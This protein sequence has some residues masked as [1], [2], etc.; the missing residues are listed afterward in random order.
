MI[1]NLKISA[2]QLPL[3]WE[4]AVKNRANIEK[5]LNQLD[6][7]FNIVLLPEM[8]NSGFTMNTEKVSETMDGPSI[9]WM[10]AWAEKLNI[11]LGGSLAIKENGKVY[12]R[13]VIV[14]S[15]GVLSQ[16]DKR[17]TFTLAEEDKSYSSG[18]GFGIFKYQGWKICLRIC[19]DLRFPV[20][21]RNT[22]NYDLLL[23]VAN[24]PADRISAW[25]TLLKARA[26]EN[27]SYVVGVNRIG[28]DFKGLNYPGH[29]S[30]YD[31]MGN[32][33]TQK[34]FNKEGI[35]GANLNYLELQGHRKQFR[36]LEDRDN[37]DL[38]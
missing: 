13:F 36:F 38:C 7:K 14:S 1:S 8:F 32:L 15:D 2:I 27:M 24:W 10:K 18:T 17:H 23:F 28:D 20:W 6:N 30:I 35:I 9:L 31:P 3:F 19:Y 12:N 29:S 5:H 33:L 22:M 37:F 25:D 26:I 16:Y 11:L 4:N 34:N 21:S